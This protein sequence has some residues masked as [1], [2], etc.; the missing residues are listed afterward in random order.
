MAA[1]QL[2][3]VE[4]RRP[5]YIGPYLL[6]GVVVERP[7]AE[8]V[9]LRRVVTVPVDLRPVR[10]CFLQRSQPGLRAAACVL[11]A[12]PLVVSGD[13]LGVAGFV[14]L[15]YQLLDHADGAGGVLDV[16]HGLRVAWR[17]LDGRMGLGGRGPADQERYLEVLALHLFGIVDHLVQRGRYEAGEADGAGHKARP[18]GR[19]LRVGVC[20]LARHAGRFVV[21][22]VGQVLQPVI[23]LGDGG[24]GEGVRL[25]DVR[26]SVHGGFVDITDHGGS[27]DREQVVVAPELCRVIRQA[28]PTVVLLGEA[29]GL[30]HGPHRAVEQ[31]DALLQQRPET[32]RPDLSLFVFRVLENHRFL[33]LRYGQVVQDLVGD[34]CGRAAVCTYLHAEGWIQRR[35]QADLDVRHAPTV[36]FRV[37]GIGGDAV[38]EDVPRGGEPEAGR[39]IDPLKSG[40]DTVEEIPPPHRHGHHQRPRR[41]LLQHAPASDEEDAPE[42]VVLEIFDSTDRTEDLVEHHPDLF[43]IVE[44]GVRYLLGQQPRYSGLTHA[45]RAVD[46]NDHPISPWAR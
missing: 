19:L 18:L 46:E 24:R 7:H 23:R 26:A 17:D 34:F 37:L 28:L 29:V 16:D 13:L 30:D 27:G 40:C 10:P 44:H 20:G 25:D 22:F 38:N 1:L 11:A 32:G 33:S 9:G 31:D 2:P 6:Q 45:K 35:P 39:L 15:A 41:N 36:G 4:E 21:Q 5:V 42:G 12:G 43:G 8:N 3:G 14:V